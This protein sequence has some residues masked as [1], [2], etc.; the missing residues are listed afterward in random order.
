MSR[1]TSRR[2]PT[3][4]GD[5]RARATGRLGTSVGERYALLP[6][7][8]ITSAAWRSLPDFAVRVA[9]ALAGAFS[10]SNNG[11]VTV[12]ASQATEHGLRP[13][14]L[15]AG[16]RVLE[17]VGLLLRTRQGHLGRGRKVPNLFAL[18]WRG[19]D[20][21]PEG[22]RYDEGIGP[23][24]IES[25]AWARFEPP[26]DWW[27]TVNGI[28]RKYRGAS[29]AERARKIPVT[30][31]AG[32]E[33]TLPYPTGRDGKG[34]TGPNRRVWKGPLT[35]PDRQATSKTSGPGGMSDATCCD[36]KT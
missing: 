21:A 17:L 22:Q 8:V 3:S 20:P 36:G 27:Q 13:W 11:A 29:G 24:P 10:G 28:K 5:K 12:T 35:V 14:E 32:T 1:R 15:Y 4:R 2:S 7:E 9:V 33:V 26:S 34:R 31:Q 16:Q 30:G 19:I 25:N 18:T 6:L 23:C